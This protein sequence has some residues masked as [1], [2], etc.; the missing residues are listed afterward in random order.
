MLKHCSFSLSVKL[1]AKAEGTLNKECMVATV[2]LLFEM[3]DKDQSPKC[4]ACEA[5][6][7]KKVG[8]PVT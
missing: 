6:I 5:S 4:I 2:E 3:Q 7:T 1:L 8:T